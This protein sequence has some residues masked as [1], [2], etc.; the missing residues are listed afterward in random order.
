MADAACMA[1][2]DGDVPFHAMRNSRKAAALCRYR[3]PFGSGA[4][5]REF[6]NDE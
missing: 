5:D 6:K 2:L 4:G 3:Q 1:V